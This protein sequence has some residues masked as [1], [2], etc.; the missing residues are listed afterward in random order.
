MGTLEQDIYN[1]KRFD[2]KL[3]NQSMNQAFLS[4]EMSK[5]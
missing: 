3:I 4:I 5:N 2:K 1:F